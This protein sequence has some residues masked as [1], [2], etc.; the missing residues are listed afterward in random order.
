L[1]IARINCAHDAEF[2]WQKIIDQIQFISK[3]L[4]KQI[5]IHKDLASPKIR[6]LT[7]KN[8]AIKIR[9]GD[10][11]WVTIPENLENN[12]GD[13][14]IACSIPEIISQL[15]NGHRILIDDGLI[16]AEIFIVKHNLVLAEIKRIA[17]KKS[18]LK[19]EKGMN[20]PDTDIRVLALTSSDLACVPFIAKNAN[21]VGYSFVKSEIDVKR[22]DQA[23]EGLPKPYLI[24]KIETLQAVYQIP[25]M[26]FEAMKEPH[27]GV[28]IARVDLAV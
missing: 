4:N 3:N 2:V 12:L 19:P 20:F 23:F 1:N 14:I 13:K 27:F 8:K 22:L 9:E 17:T 5:K 25:Q 24:L 11:L 16:E 10:V 15:K 6:T 28:M 18:L 7:P 21:M 26:L